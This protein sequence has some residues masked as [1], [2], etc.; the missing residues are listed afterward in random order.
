M[1]FHKKLW[2]AGAILPAISALSVAAISCN[3][4]KNVESADFDKLADTDKVKFVNEKIE[5]L[6]KVQKAQLIDSLDI[7]SVLSADEKAVLIDKLNKDAAQIGSVVWYIKSAE[8][9]IG[10][11]QDYAFAKV[12]FD[13]LIKDEKMKSMLDLAKV[14]STTGKVSNP[15]NGKFI[16]VVFMDIDETVLSNDFTEAN[17]MTV[18]GF[19][20]AD[21]EKYDLKGIRKATP[22]A[23]AFINHVFEKG[24]VV[25]YNSDMSQSTAVRDAV[26]LNLEKAG[27]KKEYLKN[28]QFWMRGATPYVPKE[29]TIFD[30]YKTMKSEEATKVTKD[31]LKAVAKI[32]VT[33]KFEAKPWIS[34][35]NTLIAEGIGKQFLKNMR[36]NAVSDN[37]VGW[38]FSDEKDGDAVKLR[39]MMKIGDNFN[40]FFDEASKGKSND[41]RVALFESS[42]AKMK[43]LFLSPTGAKGRKY[44][45]GVWSDLEWNQSYVLISGNSEYGG[46]LEPFGFKNTYKNLWDEVKRIIADPKDLK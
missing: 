12:K 44:T 6:S 21:K 26:K 16:P 22:G 32:E 4:T 13:N 3:T 28:W 14:D 9:R 41:E 23:I 40:D 42:E 19:N 27:I 35:P 38:N 39:V 31:E 37:T 1:K 8:S 20:P 24:G 18:G 7:K 11:E 29:A 25:M 17:A 2:L 45:K 36:M 33:D 10:R 30:K 15:D 5:K 34:W 46:W 43:D